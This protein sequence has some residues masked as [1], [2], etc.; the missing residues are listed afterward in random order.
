[1]NFLHRNGIYATGTVRRQRADL[2]L[3]IK[4]SRG[5]IL[6]LKKGDYKWRV[7]Q[8][9]SFVVWQDNKEVLLMSNA[10]HPKVG[11]T[12]V[13]RTQKDGLKMSVNCPLVIQEY[14]RR[15]GG[16]DR[17]DQLKSTYT[18]GRRSK[19]WWLRIFLLFD[20]RQHNQC[21]YFKQ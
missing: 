9:V 12:T 5:K 2:P 20:R 19:K 10:F 3:L 7:K 11:C 21:V 13:T 17:F 1:M 6:K 4:G 18:V 8:N 14:T 15:M 16:V